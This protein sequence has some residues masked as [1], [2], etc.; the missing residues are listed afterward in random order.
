MIDRLTT[1][2][3]TNQPSPA[4][5]IMFDMC[6]SSKLITRGASEERPILTSTSTNTS[7][8]TG[9]SGGVGDHDVDG[10][11]QYFLCWDPLDGSR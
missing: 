8:S 11:A 5:R 2:R 1:L 3:T 7:T 9:T 10:V 6:R 4:D